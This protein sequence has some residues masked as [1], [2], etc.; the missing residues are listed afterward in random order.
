MPTRRR[1][2]FIHAQAVWMLAV[3]VTL[4]AVGALSPELFFVLSLI[5]LL[6]VIEFTAPFNVTPRWRRRLKWFVALGLLAFAAIVVRRILAL[7][8]EGMF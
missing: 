3:L 6:V 7:L 2:Q 8:P 1:E 4:A 5:G